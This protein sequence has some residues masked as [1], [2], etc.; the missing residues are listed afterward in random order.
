MTTPLFTD[1]NSALSI[2]LETG[3]IE[4]VQRLVQSNLTP[5]SI[6]R[7]IKK[8]KR[9]ETIGA[10]LPL[11]DLDHNEYRC[12]DFDRLF[13]K[14]IVEK[15]TEGVAQLR[16]HIGKYLNNKNIAFYCGQY[17]TSPQLPI[18]CNTDYTKMIEFQEGLVSADNLDLLLLFEVTQVERLCIVVGEYCAKKSMD[19]FG[20]DDNALKNYVQG[21]MFTKNLDTFRHLLET[22]EERDRLLAQVKKAVIKEMRF[23]L[24]DLT[25]TVKWLLKEKYVSFT[26]VEWAKMKKDLPVLY[27]ALQEDV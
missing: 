27:A 16:S 5:E 25:S 23:P 19:H 22:V 17:A 14:A 1:L 12:E 26:E 15:N 6:F 10:F 2:I 21:V 9:Y 24:R 8:T 13:A 11:L 4:D 20:Y 3:T 18:E 7:G